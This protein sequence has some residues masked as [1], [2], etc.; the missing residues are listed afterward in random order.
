MA[1]YLVEGKTRTTDQMI[2]MYA[3]LA[4]DFPIVSIEDPL[5]EDD[6][7]SWV[8]FTSAMGDAIQIVGDDHYVTNTQRIARG[9]ELKSA[10]ALLGKGKPDRNLDR[11]FAGSRNGTS[12]R[13][14]N[15]DES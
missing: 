6:W 12:R 5:A 4:K 13:F 2:E 14:C 9:I 11:N 3:Q 7:D 8:N 10:N 1:K 15:H